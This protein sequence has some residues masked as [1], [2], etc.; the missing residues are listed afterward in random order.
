MLE[1]CKKGEYVARNVNPFVWYSHIHVTGSLLMRKLSFRNACPS[2]KGCRE[3]D[4][5]QEVTDI[6]VYKFGR[7][8]STTITHDHNESAILS[9]DYLVEFSSNRKSNFAEMPVIIMEGIV[10]RSGRYIHVIINEHWL[11]DYGNIQ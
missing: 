2:P 6:G 7:I 9:D 11:Q 1:F 5:L 8:N 3:R 10:S 4:S